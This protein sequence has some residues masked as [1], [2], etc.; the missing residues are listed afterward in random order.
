MRLAS[1]RNCESDGCFMAGTVIFLDCDGK[2]DACVD[3]GGGTVALISTAK[4]SFAASA[5]N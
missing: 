2:F 3:G 5:P 4:P 1:V